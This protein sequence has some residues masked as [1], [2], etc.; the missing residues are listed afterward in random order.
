MKIIAAPVLNGQ[1]NDHFGHSDEF[2]IFTID[3]DNTIKLTNSIK[4]EKRCGCKTNLVG[5][6]KS[7]KV[8]ILIAG[9]LGQGAKSKLND[10]GIDVFSGFSGDVFQA[11][12]S[13]NSGEFKFQSLV[14]EGNHTHGHNCNHH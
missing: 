13:W 4:S 6:L 5:E 9:Y 7:E 14:C 12:K 8:T 1:I 3:D 10:A 11:V 2:Q